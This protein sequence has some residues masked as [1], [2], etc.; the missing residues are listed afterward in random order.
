AGAARR[1]AN[2]PTSRVTKGSR[3]G[4]RLKIAT[5]PS[6]SPNP[7]A[8]QAQNHPQ[9]DRCGFMSCARS[10]ALAMAGQPPR[11]RDLGVVI[12]DLP[13]GPANAIT[14]V[15]GVRIGHTTLISGEG[16]LRV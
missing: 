2:A 15:A 12:G 4:P 3:S 14:D 10:M 5:K 1:R 11:A 13:T 16:P 8:V 6:T 9:W 7:P